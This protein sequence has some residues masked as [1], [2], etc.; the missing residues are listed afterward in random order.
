MENPSARAT[1]AY[2]PVIFLPIMDNYLSSFDFFFHFRRNVE[3]VEKK[4]MYEFPVCNLLNEYLVSVI[5]IK[6]KRK[7]KNKCGFR[8]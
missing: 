1:K 8:T 4:T 2:Q 7:K 3:N 5:I 6:Q